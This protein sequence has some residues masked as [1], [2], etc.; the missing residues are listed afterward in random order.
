[1][2]WYVWTFEPKRAVRRLRRGFRTWRAMAAMFGKS[3]AYWMRV[4]RGTLKMA[5]A[6]ENDFRRLLG[7]P[8]RR[9]RR[10]DRMRPE[11][12]AHIVA[13]RR[14]VHIAALTG[15]AAGYVGSGVPASHPGRPEPVPVPGLA[16]VVSR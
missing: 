16:V 15:D 13:H 4:A 9:C 8:P 2:P 10:I 12:L 6:D 11:D 3:P 7:L 5:P 14:E 1:M